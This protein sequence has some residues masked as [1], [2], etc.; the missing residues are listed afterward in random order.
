M[1]VYECI[2]RDLEFSVF[3]VWEEWAADGKKSESERKLDVISVEKKRVWRSHER[4]D[5]TL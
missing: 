3:S 5:W 4:K 1:C 2:L